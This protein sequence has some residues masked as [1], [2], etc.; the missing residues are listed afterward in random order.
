MHA[1]LMLFIYSVR[2]FHFVNFAFH[3]DMANWKRI[4]N[5]N[6]EQIRRKIK[7][8]NKQNIFGILKRTGGKSKQIDS[9]REISHQP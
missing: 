5:M 6:I 1:H 9:S 3:V 7:R 4:K 8:V 2:L